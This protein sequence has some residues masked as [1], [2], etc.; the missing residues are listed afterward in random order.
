MKHRVSWPG[1]LILGGVLCSVSLAAEPAPPGYSASGLYNLANAYAREGKVGMAVLNYERAGLLSPDDPD[2]EANLRS[3]RESAHLAQTSRSRY[4]RALRVATPRILSWLAVVGVL[5]AGS[6]L[7][8][9]QFSARFRWPRYAAMA[10]GV[11]L[12]GL[13]VGNGV[14]LWPILHEGVV[15]TA[16]TPVRVSPVPMGDPLFTLPEAETVRITAEHEGFVLVQTRAGRTGWASRANVAPV[17]PRPAAA[18]SSQ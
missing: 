18:E 6:G 1:L 17:V 10:C 15:I 11:A 16:A 9:G 8:A 7:I 3:V 13:A 2:I 12:I 5:I 14:A 4:E